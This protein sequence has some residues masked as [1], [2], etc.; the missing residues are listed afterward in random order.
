MKIYNSVKGKEKYY[1]G[2]DFDRN[3]YTFW[4]NEDIFLTT[5][6]YVLIK[7]QANQYFSGFNYDY[8]LNEG[9]K[10]FITKELEVFQIILE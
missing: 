1:F 7:D 9:E 3:F 10:Y 8:E 5:G 6:N 4:P 2:Y